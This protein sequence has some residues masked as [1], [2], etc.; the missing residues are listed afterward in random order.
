MILKKQQMNEEPATLTHKEKY[1]VFVTGTTEIIALPDV[2][3]L[4]FSEFWGFCPTKAA[5]TLS[6]PS[7]IA[8]SVLQSS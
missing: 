6:W 4:F 1:G 5:H 2:F 3:W 8:W 7:G